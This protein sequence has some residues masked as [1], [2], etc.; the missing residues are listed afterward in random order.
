MRAV[1]VPASIRALPRRS[2]WKQQALSA[3][4]KI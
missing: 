3:A 4:C 1:N 2:L